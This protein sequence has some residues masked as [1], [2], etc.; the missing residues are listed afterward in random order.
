[1]IARFTKHLGLVASLAVAV[2]LAA[3]SDS[4]KNPRLYVNLIWHQHQP[5]YTDP[6]GNFARGPWVRKHGVKDYYDMAATV[7]KYPKVH[8]S[9][10][11]TPVLLMQLDRFYLQRLKDYVDLANDTMSDANAAAFLASNDGHVVTDPW[12]DMLVAPTPDPAT[13]TDQQKAYFWRDI[14]STFSISDP[15]LNR[16]PEYKALR[17]KRTAAQGADIAIRLATAG[18]DGPTGGFFDDDGTVPW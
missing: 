16:F 11:L 18:L 9:I 4:T 2:A 17:D 7:A 12:L 14:W 13:M 15:M 8:V 6:V 10:N 1:M 3:C 5:V